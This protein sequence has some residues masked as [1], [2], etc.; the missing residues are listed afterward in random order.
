MVKV[1][2]LLK[3]ASSLISRIQ[4]SPATP[5]I[6]LFESRSMYACSDVDHGATIITLQPI[7]IIKFSSSIAGQLSQRLVLASLQLNIM[8][9]EHKYR[10]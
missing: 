7:G 5:A 4:L 8:H 6:T 9:G 3:L 1:N 2:L 10:S